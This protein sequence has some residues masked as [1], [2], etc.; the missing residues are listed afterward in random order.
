MSK[1]RVART[2]DKELDKLA[3]VT[4]EDVERA[5]E[6]WRRNAPKQARDLLDAEPVDEEQGLDGVPVE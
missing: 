1:R 4:P 5:K 3:E 2:S 6:Y